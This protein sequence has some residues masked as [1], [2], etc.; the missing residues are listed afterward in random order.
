MESRTTGRHSLS[1]SHSF[2]PRTR[3]DVRVVNPDIRSR[4]HVPFV[5][6]RDPHRRHRRH[7]TRPAAQPR[8]CTPMRGRD[9]RRVGEVRAL[10]LPGAPQV[11]RR[12]AEGLESGT[13]SRCAHQRASREAQHEVARA[14]RDE[15]RRAQRPMRRWRR[16]A[17]VDDR[18]G[19][20]HVSE[21]RERLVHECDRQLRRHRRLR[22]LHRHRGGRASRR[23]HVRQLHPGTGR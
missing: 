4:P 22:V 19:H 11:Q 3:R 13:V 23:A 20:R 7:R 8:R 5:L 6:C 16:P 10:L 15:L 9:Q 17:A 2:A 1:A 14:D 12:G 18:L 21:L